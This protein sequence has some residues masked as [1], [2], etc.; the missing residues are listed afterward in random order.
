MLLYKEAR[1]ALPFKRTSPRRQSNETNA[2]T[3]KPMRW[4][5]TEAAV[6]LVERGAR[7]LSGTRDTV[8]V[9][10]HSCFLLF[11]LLDRAGLTA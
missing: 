1:I 3:N 4:C 6:K 9:F 10:L 8:L 5:L 2:E 11:V 7:L